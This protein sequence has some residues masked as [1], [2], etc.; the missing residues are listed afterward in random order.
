MRRGASTHAPRD[1]SIERS[2]AAENRVERRDVTSAHAS[3]AR[4]TLIGNSTF[5]RQRSFLVSKCVLLPTIYVHVY[6]GAVEC[7]RS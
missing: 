1:F 2:Y 7:V 4:L 3:A 5:T 6:V